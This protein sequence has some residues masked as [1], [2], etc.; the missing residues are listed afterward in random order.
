MSSGENHNVTKVRIV[1]WTASEGN[2]LFVPHNYYVGSEEVVSVLTRQ[3]SVIRGLCA[4]R[5]IDHG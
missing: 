2:E 3:I 4:L 1:E 5:R